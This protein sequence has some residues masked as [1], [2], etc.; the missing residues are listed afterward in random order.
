MLGSPQLRCKGGTNNFVLQPGR[1]RLRERVWPQGPVGEAGL[2]LVLLILSQAVVWVLRL[3]AGPRLRLRDAWE[4]AGSLGPEPGFL[5][6]P[7]M[8]AWFQ[9][10][11]S[12]LSPSH[13]G[14]GPERGLGQGEGLS[15]HT[16]EKPSLPLSLP[17]PQRHQPAHP[18][19]VRRA[20]SNS[21]QNP[22]R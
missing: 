2:L 9:G 6:G 4:E 14:A 20:L 13:R 19:T 11:L 17:P 1:F 18:S 21:A 16:G 15:G 22:E 8:P 7:P 12:P 3:G 10:P 5:V